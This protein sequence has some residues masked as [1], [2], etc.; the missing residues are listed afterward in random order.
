[1]CSVVALGF[2][3]HNQDFI[4][5]GFGDQAKIDAIGW[6]ILPREDDLMVW[7][8]ETVPRK[9]EPMKPN[10]GGWAPNRSHIVQWMDPVEGRRHADVHFY[11]AGDCDDDVNVN[12]VW[13]DLKRVDNVLSS[14]TRRHLRKKRK[15]LLMQQ[16]FKCV[17]RVMKERD[18]VSKP[19]ARAMFNKIVK[20]ET[21]PLWVSGIT[22]DLSRELVGTAMQLY[23][24]L[25]FL[26]Q[27]GVV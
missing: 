21:T 4:E 16:Y 18:F 10:F 7:A 11:K 3:Y 23:D 6:T 19:G 13:F 25:A 17:L 22:P 15:G 9:G 24:A 2:F 26:V 14:D 20:V 27:H 1:M 8:Y 12:R 5:S